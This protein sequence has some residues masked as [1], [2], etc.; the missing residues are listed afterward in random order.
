MVYGFIFLLGMVAGF[1][2][3]LAC[4]EAIRASENAHVRAKQGE[5]MATRRGRRLI[6]IL[7]MA[8]GILLMA[9][10]FF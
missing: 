9:P 2:L 6:G 7:L 4:R 5:T 3:C 10:A 8:L 1:A